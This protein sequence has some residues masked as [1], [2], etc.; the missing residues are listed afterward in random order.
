MN[1]P[2]AEPSGYPYDCN[3]LFFPTIVTISFPRP[4]PNPFVI[5]RSLSRKHC[6]GVYIG[7]CH[8]PRAEAPWL[9]SA[10]PVG[11]L[12]VPCTCYC[13]ASPIRPNTNSPTLPISL[14]PIHSPPRQGSCSLTRQC[15][16]AA[17]PGLQ[18]RAL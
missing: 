18:G 14:S 5:D 10:I 7:H 4:I 15:S 1:Y 3:L 12:F 13:A 11:I 6:L 16:G 2:E 8:Q 17:L 9:H